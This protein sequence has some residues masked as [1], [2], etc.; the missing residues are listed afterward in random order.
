MYE[1]VLVVGL[2]E[3]ADL[4][5]FGRIDAMEEFWSLLHLFVV[6]ECLIK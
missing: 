4:K 3:A 2:R 6:F 1:R 5:E